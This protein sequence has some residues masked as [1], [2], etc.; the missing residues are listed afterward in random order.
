MEL[1]RQGLRSRS[2][3]SLLIPLQCREVLT[4]AKSVGSLRESQW[5]RKGGTELRG[6]PTAVLRTPL[7]GELTSRG[8]NSGLVSKVFEINF[9]ANEEPI[10]VTL[11]NYRH[12]VNDPVIPQYMVPILLG[13]PR[14]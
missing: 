13:P 14:Q 6:L 4:P 11:I 7:A 12:R 5:G 2:V 3:E 1:R 9:S 8:S 10:S